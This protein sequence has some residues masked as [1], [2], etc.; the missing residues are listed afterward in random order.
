M[1]HKS[2]SINNDLIKGLNI[3]SKDMDRLDKLNINNKP[4]HINNSFNQH[5]ANNNNN[6]NN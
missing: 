3:V 5:N 1:T 4:R 6:M 2:N